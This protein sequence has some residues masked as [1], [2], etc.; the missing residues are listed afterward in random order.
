MKRSPPPK[1]KARLRRTELKRISPAEAKRRAEER[2]RKRKEREAAT[3]EAMAE[4]KWLRAQVNSTTYATCSVCYQMH[5][6]CNVEVD[7][8]QPLM[9]GGTNDP[10]NIQI[11]CKSCHRKKTTEQAQRKHRLPSKGVRRGLA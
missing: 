6:S 4:R 10:G 8:V 9:E 2:K 1:R 11:L 7:H 3:R 5:L